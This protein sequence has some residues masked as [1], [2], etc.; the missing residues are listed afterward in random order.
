MSYISGYHL[1]VV[2]N[3][4]ISHSTFFKRHIALEY[5]RDLEIIAANT[6]GYCS[7]NVKNNIADVASKHSTDMAL[8][9]TINRKELCDPVE[10]KTFMIKLSSSPFL[11]A[12][13]TFTHNSSVR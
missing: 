8:T 6:L 2:T 3:S 10:E 1:A 11:F 9:E 13:T 12:S 4:S 7:V 5:H